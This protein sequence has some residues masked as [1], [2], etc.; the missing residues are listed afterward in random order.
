MQNIAV[1]LRDHAYQLSGLAHDCLDSVASNRLERM[2]SQVL[3]KAKRLED[4]ARPREL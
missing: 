2:S 3:D 4:A 1:Y